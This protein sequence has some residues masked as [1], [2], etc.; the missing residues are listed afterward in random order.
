MRTPSGAALLGFLHLETAEGAA[1]LHEG[2]LALDRE[3]HRLQALVIRGRPVVHEDDLAV[4]LAGR[5]VAVERGE[6]P[7]H[8][9]VFVLRVVVLDEREFFHARFHH[10]ERDAL[11]MVEEHVVLHHLDFEAELL[12]LREHPVGDLLLGRRARDVAVFG[13]GEEP[14]L[15]VLGRRRVEE[16]LLE[17]RVRVGGGAGVAGGRLRGV[18]GERQ[19]RRQGEGR[20]QGEGSQGARMA[21]FGDLLHRR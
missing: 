7:A 9:R 19:A 1:V 17:G 8:R 4:G 3:A 21:H 20:K 10:L 2:D 18:G 11:R 13:E 5:A 12:E 15:C 14:A 6:L 16:H